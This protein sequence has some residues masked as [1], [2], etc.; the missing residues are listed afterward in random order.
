MRGL[1]LFGLGVL[2]VGTADAATT[3]TTK[4]KKPPAK[5]V[6]TPPPRPPP[7]ANPPSDAPRAPCALTGLPEAQVVWDDPGYLWLVESN[8]TLYVT[9][10]GGPLPRGHTN[11]RCD[12]QTL[13][14]EVVE[15]GTSLSVMQ[16]DL[17][18]SSV[19]AIEAPRHTPQ[20][21]A[22]RAARASLEAG[23]V[24][25]ARAV[26]RS[27]DRTDEEVGELWVWVSK[28]EVQANNPTGAHEALRGLHMEWYGVPE[29]HV[30]AARL[31][32]K[33]A[34]AQLA[35]GAYGDGLLTMSPVEG[36]LTRNV[37]ERL[38]PPAERLDAAELIGRLK[39]GLGDAP[40]AVKTL[41]PVVSADP[42]RGQ[43]WLTLADARWEANDKKGARDA[44]AQALARLPAGSAPPTLAE[45]C[46]KCL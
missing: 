19:I 14:L 15:G 41:E 12:G 35:A 46:P 17:D 39:L 6:V 36:L 44:Y 3:T 1:T 38:W 37:P 8:E 10:L 45:R 2:L 29:A 40:A 5:T 28:L 24:A 16:F 33:T 26:L 31:S 42:A 13:R 43:A 18:F 23:D 11:T 9:A 22:W 7:P 32:V 20:A 34:T 27:L 21:K 4:K 30:A 25:G